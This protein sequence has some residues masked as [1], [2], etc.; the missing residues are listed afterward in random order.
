MDITQLLL[1]LSTE[2][3][4]PLANLLGPSQHLTFLGLHSLLT[5][6]RE[7]TGLIWQY[8]T[9]VCGFI[10]S[11]VAFLFI[12]PVLPKNLLK[13]LRNVIIF[14]FRKLLLIFLILV[15]EQLLIFHL[16]TFFLLHGL[17][18]IF[19]QLVIQI[20]NR[21]WIFDAVFD[22]LAGYFNALLDIVLICWAFMVRLRV[23]I[24]WFVYVWLVITSCHLWWRVNI[25]NIILIW[26][27]VVKI[28]IILL[29]NWLAHT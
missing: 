6:L 29:T 14:L 24:V 11:T 9:M 13:L 5:Q 28:L 22:L 2:K 3:F 18:I 21:F 17:N 20:E 1:I 8:G 25:S 26:I 15:S 16:K 23:S 19:K 12:N 7:G 4:P 27:A 10:F